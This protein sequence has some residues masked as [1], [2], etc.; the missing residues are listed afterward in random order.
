MKIINT[1]T[2]FVE[3]KGKENIYSDAWYAFVGAIVAYVF[4]YVGVRI[5][6]RANKGGDL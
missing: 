5:I 2:A 1:L 4:A 3:H 6:R